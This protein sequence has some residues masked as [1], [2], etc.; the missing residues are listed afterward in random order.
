MQVALLIASFAVVA[1]LASADHLARN[2]ARHNPEKFAAFEGVYETKP[3]TGIYAFGWVDSKEQKVH[4]LGVPG[5]LSFLVHRDFNEPVQGL[6][7]FPREHWPNVPLVFQVY[8][9]MIAMWGLMLIATCIG[10]FM[11]RGKGWTTHPLLMKFLVISVAFPQ[12]GSLA[13]WYAAEFGRQPWTVYKLLK[14]SHAYS[15]GVT[16]E[17]ALLSLTLIIILYLTFFIL[18]LV[19]LDKKIKHGPT[20]LFE[21]APYRDPYKQH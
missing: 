17:Q 15:G 14:T 21:E 13:G 8:H 3:N 16:F 4:G 20:D 19:L 2:V 7:Q 18:F 6:D 9:I 12:I 11:W 5:L 10:L 1:Q